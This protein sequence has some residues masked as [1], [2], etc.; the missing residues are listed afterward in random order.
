MLS[1]DRLFEF[2]LEVIYYCNRFWLIEWCVW[3]NG[4]RQVMEMTEITGGLYGYVEE[5]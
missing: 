5:E 4:E 2:D 1:E 3:W